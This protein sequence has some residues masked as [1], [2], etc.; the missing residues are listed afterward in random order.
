VGLIG[1][2]ALATTD[3]LVQQV[4]AAVAVGAA[5]ATATYGVYMARL[6]G[7]LLGQVSAPSR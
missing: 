4:W 5:L 1:V 6:A 7:H 2:V 3:L